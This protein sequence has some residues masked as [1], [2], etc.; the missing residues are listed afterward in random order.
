MSVSVCDAQVKLHSLKKHPDHLSF[1]SE[2][3]EH[4]E[5]SQEAEDRKK[6]EGQRAVC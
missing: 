4:W 5:A 2:R 6:N 3:T 1:A